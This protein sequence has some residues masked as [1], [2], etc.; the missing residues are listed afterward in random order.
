MTASVSLDTKLVEEALATGGVKSKRNIVK[1]A[2]EELIKIHH[3]LEIFELAG[4]IEYVDGYWDDDDF[5]LA[6]L[7]S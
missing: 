2:L 1:L 4:Q 3:Q 7:H 6:D 5:S